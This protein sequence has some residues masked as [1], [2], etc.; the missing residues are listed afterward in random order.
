M[1][2]A[3]N[4]GGR[5]RNTLNR[6]QNDA[7]YAQRQGRRLPVVDPDRVVIMGLS[8]GGLT[9]ATLRPQKGEVARIIEGWTCQAGWSEYK[10]M[11]ASASTPVLALVGSKDPWHQNKWTRGNCTRNL[12]SSNGSRSVVYTSGTLAAEH[13]LLD[14]AQPKQDVIRFLT[15]I[16]LIQ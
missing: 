15:Q 14:H 16:G 1:D 10:G 4:L 7:R 13:E 8:E 12:R 6:R 5:L 3:T 11:N 9:T 2:V